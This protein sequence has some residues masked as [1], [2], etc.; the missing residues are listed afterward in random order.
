[1]RKIIKNKLKKVKRFYI[2][3]VLIKNKPKIF[4]IGRNKTGTTSLKKAFQDLGF[5]VGHQRTAERLIRDYKVG[6][7]EPIFQYCKSAQV[8]QDVP[9]SYSKTFKHLD[10]AY[11]N[12]KFILSV[13]DSPEQWY[14]SVIKFH[15]KLFGNGK[16]PTAEQLKN[17]NY[18]WRGW[19]WESNRIN[20]NSP[21]YNPYNKESLIE[22]YLNHN[23]EVLDYFKDRPN[24]LLVIN[25][26][27]EGSYQKFIEF[28]DV[29]SSKKSFPW[30]NKT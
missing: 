12:S 21:E 4:C 18:V 16:T 19:I 14:N 2:N 27:E 13:R 15:A 5:I 8:F 1:M 11:P 10:K 9:F 29:K 26:S 3:P 7:F 17:S 6:N 20:F 24:D 30:E 25:L 28:I 22:N 23:M